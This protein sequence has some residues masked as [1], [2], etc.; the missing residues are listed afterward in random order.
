LRV[1][2]GLYYGYLL[3]DAV[4]YHIPLRCRNTVPY[5]KFAGQL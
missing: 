2:G 1:V 3:T 4:P 5:H